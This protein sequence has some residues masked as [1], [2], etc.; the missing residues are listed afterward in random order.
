M[1]LWMG[2]IVHKWM[3][4][5]DVTLR[6]QSISSILSMNWWI[7]NRVLRRVLCT[8]LNIL[9]YGPLCPAQ[10]YRRYFWNNFLLLVIQLMKM[11]M[12][13]CVCF[14]QLF[15]L[16][17]LHFIKERLYE[18]R[19]SQCHCHVIILTISKLSFSAE[20]QM[21]CSQWEELVLT[22]LANERRLSSHTWPMQRDCHQAT[23]QSTR[24]FCLLGKQQA[25]TTSK[26]FNWF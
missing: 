15:I 10:V 23:D 9:T 18:S 26:F 21:I 24:G 19:V 12:N 25:R 7:T 3:S 22:H 2:I 5:I 11:K 1:V 20:P 14:K 13:V 17:L 6:W 16:A 4:P 8:L